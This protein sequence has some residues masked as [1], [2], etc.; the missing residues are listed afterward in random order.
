M[1]TTVKT[2]LLA[3]IKSELTSLRV[4]YN[5]Y[6]TLQLEYDNIV[7]CRVHALQQFRE[8]TRTL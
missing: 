6:I 2:T 3:T 4:G 8:N 7:K 1:R 5:R